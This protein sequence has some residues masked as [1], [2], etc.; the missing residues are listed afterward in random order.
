MT[1]GDIFYCGIALLA[2]AS[3]GL[4]YFGGLWWTVRRLPR[5]PNP[6]LWSFGSFWI[7]MTISLVAFYSVMGGRPERLLISVLGFTMVRIVLVRRLKPAAAPV[8]RLG[9]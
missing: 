4:F 9:K 6:V 7:R 5:S 2:G 1:A 3:I 8:T